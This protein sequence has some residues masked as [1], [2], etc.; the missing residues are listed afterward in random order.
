M[1]RMTTVALLRRHGRGESPRLA[2]DD[3]KTVK[4]A[5]FDLFHLRLL[6]VY[7]SIMTDIMDIL[8]QKELFFEIENCVITAGYPG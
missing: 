2:T 6:W 4:I 3:R 8:C 7:G 1:L 5:L